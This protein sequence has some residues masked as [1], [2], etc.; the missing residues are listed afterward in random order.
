[1]PFLAHLARCCTAWGW[2][3]QNTVKLQATAKEFVG[4]KIPL[5]R[6]R[7]ENKPGPGAQ[8]EL[9]VHGAGAFHCL[10]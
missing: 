1:M 2:S 3:D 4:I 7:R 9:D 10:H 8:I 5:M 6:V